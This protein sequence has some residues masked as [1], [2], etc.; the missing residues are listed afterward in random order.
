[1]AQLLRLAPLAQDFACRLPLRS[2]RQNGSTLDFGMKGRGTERRTSDDCRDRVI[3]KS[4]PFH[5]R[6]R[7]CHTSIV[8]M[9]WRKSFRPWDGRG[10][11]GGKAQAIGYDGEFKEGIRHDL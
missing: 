1:M 9:R 6:G 11:E 3:G 5:R 2:R 4:E 8:G 10:G 7:R